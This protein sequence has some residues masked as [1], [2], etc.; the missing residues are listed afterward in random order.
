MFLIMNN[1]SLIIF[2][3]LKIMKIITISLCIPT[4]SFEITNKKHLI[5]KIYKIS[6]LILNYNDS[7][8]LKY[9]MY[10][11]EMKIH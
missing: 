9:F 5:N 8:I 2:L 10:L 11:K 1:V 6:L 3:N 4:F 7:I